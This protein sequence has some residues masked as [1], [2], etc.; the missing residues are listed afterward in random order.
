[1]STSKHT[2]T[3]SYGG[4][5]N[6]SVSNDSAS[7]TPLVLTISQAKSFTG[8]VFASVPSPVHGQ[9]VTLTVAVRAIGP[10]TGVPTG[11]VAFSD[12]NGPLGTGTVNASNLAT[13]TTSTLS[14]SKHTITAS[15]AGDS[16]F[17]ASNDTASTT[18]LVLTINQIGTVASSTTAAIAGHSPTPTAAADAYFASIA[19]GHQA[20]ALGRIGPL[21]GVEQ[22]D[23]FWRPAT[24]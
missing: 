14:T 17:S 7:T 3:A 6:F 21:D 11:T 12:Q 18:P 13:F 24:T 9:I 4:D 23:W 1:L 10:G 16:N 19:T 5:S 2:I 8:N 15:Y 22:M 20:A